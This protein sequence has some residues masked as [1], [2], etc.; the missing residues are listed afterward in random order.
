VNEQVHEGHSGREDAS[1]V[2]GLNP[3]AID[4][5]LLPTGLSPSLLLRGVKHLMEDLEV[6]LL[7]VDGYDL[8]VGRV[9]HLS[10]PF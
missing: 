5:V 2:E 4:S 9:V 7:G 8:V 10:S 6:I 3:K 1:D